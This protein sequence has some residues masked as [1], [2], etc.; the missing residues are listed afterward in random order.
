LHEAERKEIDLNAGIE[1]TVAIARVSA[2]PKRV[3]VV[4]DLAEL[5]HITC[6]PAKLNQ[7]VLNLLTNAIDASPR[8]GTVT[9]RTRLDPEGGVALD[10]I[11]P[12]RGIAPS[13]RE[14][15]FEPFFTTKPIGQGTGLGLSIAYGIVQLHGGRIEFE[16]EPERGTRFTVHLPLISSVPTPEGPD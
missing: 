4:T 3:E 6:Y 8:G 11:D 1:T 5:P 12:G 2:W 10:V 14:K 16:S 13:T 15:I 9:I 7:V